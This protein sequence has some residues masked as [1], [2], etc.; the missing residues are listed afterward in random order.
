MPLLEGRA[1]PIASVL[2]FQ[3]YQ[4][5]VSLASGAWKWT[6][7]VDVSGS[8]VATQIRDVISPFGLLR[9]SIPI[10]GEVAQAMAESIEQVVNT[11]APSIL[12]SPTTLSFVV[13]EGRGGSA[14]QP[15]QVTNNG[16]LGSLLSVQVTASAPYLAATPANVSGLASN[17]SGTFCVSVDSTDLVAAASPYT[18][19][20]KVQGHMAT[21]T[22]QD[23]PVEVTV[24]PKATIF[25][26]ATNLEFHVTA[27]LNGLYPPVPSQ[28][29]ALSNS[30]PGTSVLDYQI[31]QL[32]G[33]SWLAA[34]SPT[35]GQISGST[36]RPITVLV[37]PPDGTL[38][39]IYTETLRISGYST[40]MIE[41][42]V[43]TLRIT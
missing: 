17:V 10:P 43:V 28:I 24:R 8:Q 38:P 3:D 36:A 15:V 7:R 19:T 41:D 6:T 9:D 26:G 32:V 34:V 40:N 27:P 21:N 2:R 16:I 23:I 4:F 14:A 25:A 31:R 33:A 12:L 39:G 5:Q 42:I 35:H 22:P 20:L 37:S 18:A 30:G 1:L 13:D 11:Y 29:V